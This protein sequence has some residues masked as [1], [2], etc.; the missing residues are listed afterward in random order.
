MAASELCGAL[1]EPKLKFFVQGARFGP[2]AAWH[3][4]CLMGVLILV[5]GQVLIEIYVDLIGPTGFKDVLRTG[6]T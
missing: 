2:S 1:D 6:I 3:E 4:S 5:C